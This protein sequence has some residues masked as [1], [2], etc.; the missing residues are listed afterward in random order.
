MTPNVPPATVASP[1]ADLSYRNY[2]GPLKT[3]AIRWWVITMGG[4][5]LIWSKPWFYF[6]AA[7]PFLR[8]LIAGFLLYFVPQLTGGRFNPLMP[9]EQK[10][11]LAFWSALCGNFNSLAIFGVALSVGASSIAADNQANALLVYLS[12]PL[13]KGDYLLGKWMSVFL[14][15]FAVTLGPLLLLYVFCL[16]S[17]RE[18]GF[19]SNDPWMIVHLVLAAMVPAVLHAS[20]LIG[21]SAWSK[22]PRIVGAIYASLYFIGGIIVSLLGLI[23]Y[24]D[25]PTAREFVNHCSISGIIDAVSQNIMHVKLPVMQGLQNM[26]DDLENLIKWEQPPLWPFLLMGLGLV[27]VSLA[28]ARAKINAVEVVRG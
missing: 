10:Y 15:I 25:N 3:R 21:I 19:F 28:A 26:G 20:L 12:K 24:H 6:I 11:S 5:R 22:S 18:D 7:M 27:G 9:P 17:F 2:D 23:L 13:S 1:I 8:F 14:T 16:G 4:L